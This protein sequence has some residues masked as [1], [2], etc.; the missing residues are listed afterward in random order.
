MR[1]GDV[2]VQHGGGDM[3]VSEEGLERSDVHALHQKGSRYAVP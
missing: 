1:V 3:S 2:G